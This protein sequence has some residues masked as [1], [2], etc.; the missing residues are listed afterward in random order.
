VG[1]H[2]GKKKKTM[3]H[4]DLKEKKW[5]VDVPL[6]LEGGEKSASRK[7]YNKEEKTTLS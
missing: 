1:K 6:F 2:E 3:T 7:R 4:G 5:R